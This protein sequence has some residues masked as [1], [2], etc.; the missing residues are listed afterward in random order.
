MTRFAIVLWLLIAGAIFALSEAAHAQTAGYGLNPGDVLRISVWK[1]EGLDHEVLVLPDGSISFPLAGH[2]NVAGR[3]ALEV[4][5]ALIARIGEYIPDPAIT[6]S[7]LNVSGNKIYVIGQVNRPG[8][9][10]VS[11][12]ID[13]MQALS[14]AGGL[15]AFGDQDDIIILRREAGQR[16]VFPF[17][18]SAVKRGEELETNIVLRSGDVVVVPD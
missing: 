3:T 10:P 12:P 14:L 6:V 16:R 8:E 13:V 1:E 4:E 7:V 15:T 9:F 11:Q 2:L 5:Q 18:F 17:D